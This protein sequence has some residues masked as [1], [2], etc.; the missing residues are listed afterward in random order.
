M[1][2]KRFIDIHNSRVSNGLETSTPSKD[3]NASNISNISG[4]SGVKPYLRNNELII[5]TG[6]ADKY[7]WWAD[8]QSIFLTLLELN[9]PDNA[10]EKYV[11]EIGSPDNWRKWQEIRKNEIVSHETNGLMRPFK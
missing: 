7:R 8:G 10:I 5:P 9:A 6:S 11:G 2:R 4:L 1:K 3:R